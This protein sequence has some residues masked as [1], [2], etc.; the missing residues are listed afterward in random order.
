MFIAGIVVY[1]INA[2]NAMEKETT[3]YSDLG[4]AAFPV[5]YTNYNGQ[6]IN[7]LHGYIK[8]MGN[9]AA[10]DQISV[11]PENR[12][13]NLNIKEYGNTVTGIRYE[14]RNLSLDRLIERTE[15][16]DWSSQDGITST[17]LQIQNL[18]SKNEDYLLSLQI[19]IA[20]QTLYYYTRIMWVENTYVAE[21]LELAESFSRKSLDYD[22]ARELVMYLETNDR[23]DNSSLGHVNIRSSF[24]HLTWD[25][26]DVEMEG[27]P[28]ITVKEFDGIM[29]QLQIRYRV[30]INEDNGISTIVDTEDNYVMRWN[31]QRIYLMN[32]ERYAN[33][34][35]T[36][37]SQK[38]S[39]KRILLGISNTENIS[40]V[41]D[42]DS[43]YIAF[44]VNGN[45]WS[46]DQKDRKLLCIFS[47]SSEKDDGVRSGYDR[48]GIKILSVDGEGS[49]NF[50]VYGYMN[51]GKYEG[52]MGVVCYS[53]DKVSDT[54]KEKFF[55]P[56]IES[57]D[58]LKSD[59]D[60]LSYLSS[61]DMLYLMLQNGVYGIDLKSNESLVVAQR[62]EEGT[63]AV[64]SDGSRF[65][66][67]EGSDIYQSKQIHVM[68]FDTAQKQEIISKEG[69]YVRGLG[70]VG[71]DLI[72]GFGK[73]EDSWV[74]NG[75]IKGLPLYAIYI[76]D[77]QMNI[78]NEYRK[79]G[80]YIADVAV[81]EGRIHL[82]RYR[83]SENHQ[84]VYQDEDTIVCNQELENDP[85]KNIGWF[86]SQNMGKLYFV[87]ADFDIKS[88]AIKVSAPKT[89]SYEN[90]NTLEL[91]TEENVGDTTELFYA[92]SGGRFLGAYRS[93]S[94]AVDMA[95]DRMGYVTDGEQ[96][97][98][99]D[100]VNRR[101]TRNIK[102]PVEA[103]NAVI[104]QLD[105]FGKSGMHRKAGI[106]IIDADGCILNQMLYF[107]DKGIPVVAYTNPG[108][109]VLLSGYDQYNIAI[110]DP[111]TQESWK[112]GLTD[113]GEYFNSLQ[114]D[115]VCAVT[116]E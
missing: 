115:F 83:K 87:Q 48:H 95:Y 11:L 37:S 10:R 16:T 46:Y 93:F 42:Q 80:I 35:F 36:G 68:D 4:E 6:D 108:Q 31:E 63:F 62:L 39:G 98:L 47:F 1:F 29:G 97:I 53:Y 23:E 71:N 44:T 57:Y 85:F 70:F 94:K 107:I 2:R 3:V 113:A 77:K 102:S 28:E 72:Y 92:Y 19:D 18:I 41:K 82:K 74:V 40:S 105:S 14:I 64:S 45:L 24:K 50:L 81:E 110:Y 52:Q 9:Q 54:V 111:Q 114:N 56:V 20:E 17:A 106:I 116:V 76:A 88:S 69:D 51:R 7:C 89:F 58:K 13:L 104:N 55:I 84:Y 100:R 25:G 27:E 26:L 66:W 109:Y 49:V 60:R 101:S 43:R 22:Q 96:H 67:Q 73:S 79:E 32:Y 34:I 103:A 86:A 78:E 21:M 8:D 5:V 61:N 99:W 38:F 90:T 59:I 30:R 65:A 15:V 12:V 75:R 33:E 112:M 91:W